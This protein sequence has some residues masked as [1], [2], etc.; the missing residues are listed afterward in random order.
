MRVLKHN[1]IIYNLF[2]SKKKKTN[3]IQ[4]VP[5]SLPELNRVRDDGAAHRG[6]VPSRFLQAPSGLLFPNGFSTASVRG[7]E[8][9][10]LDVVQQT[11]NQLK[12]VVFVVCDD[13]IIAQIAETMFRVQTQ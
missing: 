6:P 3:D 11:P 8:F 12:F 2:F 4:F 5:E 1:T 10:R 7:A 13:P 9:L